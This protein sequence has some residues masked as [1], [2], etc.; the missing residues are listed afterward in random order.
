MTTDLSAEKVEAEALAKRIAKLNPWTDMRWPED[1]RE[2]AAMLRAQAARIAELEADQSAAD[3][4]DM[5]LIAHMDGRGR[6]KN[7]AEAEVSRIAELERERDEAREV[8]KSA[9]DIVGNIADRMAADKAF[10]QHF[11][12]TLSEFQK[13]RGS[14][15]L[16]SEGVLPPGYTSALTAAE[17][18]AARLKGVVERLRSA[19]EPFCHPGPEYYE[20]DDMTWGP[21]RRLVHFR[22]ARAALDA[23]KE[24]QA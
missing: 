14:L 8:L 1:C 11:P 13:G 9:A 6:G 5:L 2:A 7:S 20:M 24:P 16:A 17:A 19:L 3:V 21:P 4:E 23:T 12:N 15:L 22:A 18:E 10:I